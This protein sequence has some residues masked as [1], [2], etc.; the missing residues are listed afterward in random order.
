MHLLN[1]RLVD[2]AEH[3]R[4]VSPETQANRLARQ[5]AKLGF[6]CVLTP[7]AASSVSV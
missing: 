3:F 6:D 2:L 4:R 5:I 7:A 1:F